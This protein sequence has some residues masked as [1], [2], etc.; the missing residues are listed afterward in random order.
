MWQ[1]KQD[2]GYSESW[3]V[4]HM[5]AMPVQI[6]AAPHQPFDEGCSKLRVG[7]VYSWQGQF[8]TAG[9]RQRQKSIVERYRRTREQATW[10]D[11][12]TSACKYQNVFQIHCKLTWT[13][14][15]LKLKSIIIHF[16][17]HQM[18]HTHPGSLENTGM[19]SLPHLIHVQM[20]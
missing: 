10:W 20:V 17:Y 13:Q 7:G 14:G 3:A 8:V 19:Q 12:I 11:C 2:I 5:T 18:F 4:N 15:R 9:W 6:S 16:T 1:S